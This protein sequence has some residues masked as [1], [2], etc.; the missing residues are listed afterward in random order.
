MDWVKLAPYFYVKTV[1]SRQQVSVTGFLIN[2]HVVK[3]HLFVRLSTVRLKITL[4][5]QVI[6]PQAC[7][8][9]SVSLNSK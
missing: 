2:V 9:G 1:G 4:T 3:T 8:Q 5:S 7:Q 6:L